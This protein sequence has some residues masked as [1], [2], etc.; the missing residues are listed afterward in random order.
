VSVASLL[1]AGVGAAPA[2]GHRD[3]VAGSQRAWL[4]AAEN[5]EMNVDFDVPSLRGL[6]VPL[7]E[8]INIMKAASMGRG[9]IQAL[10]DKIMLHRILNN[11]G[12]SQMPANLIIEGPLVNQ[13]EVEQ[14]LH[15]HLSDPGFA[16]AVVKPSHLSNSSG[17]L[18]VRAPLK[19]DKVYPI[20]QMI[21][22]HIRQFMRE[23]AAP[24]ESAALRSLKPGFMVQ[25]K[26]ANCGF[27]KPL[28]IRVV[29]L[30]GKARVAVWW[31]GGTPEEGSERNSWLVRRPAHRDTLDLGADDWELIHRHYAVDPNFDRAIE[32][33]RQHVQE[34]A[35]TAEMISTAVGA[36][37]MRTDFFVGDSKWGVRLNEVAYGSGIEYLTRDSSGRLVDDAPAIAEIIQEGMAR[38]RRRV[39]PQQLL[40]RLGVWGNNYEEL[41][42]TP[43]KAMPQMVTPQEQ[44]E[45]GN[46]ANQDFI[47]ERVVSLDY[48]VN[49][50]G[51][52]GE[53][54]TGWVLKETRIKHSQGRELHPDGRTYEGQY[55]YDKWN[56]QATISTLV[57]GDVYVGQYKDG[58]RS[59]EGKYTHANGEIYDGHWE[60][61]KR[62]G[63]GTNT[64]V[65][66]AKYV[67]ECKDNKR[68]G[69]GK[70]TYA[71]GDVYDGHWDNNNKSGKGKYTHAN[72]ETY[73]GHWENDKSNGQGTNTW[74]SGAKYVGEYKDGKRSGEG[75]Y[76]KPN[77][78]T[79]IGHWENDS[80][81]GYGKLTSASGEVQEGQWKN[82]KFVG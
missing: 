18:L 13:R 34:M 36:P 45:A 8:V 21:G 23:T 50:L 15:T 16:G 80:M 5:F 20:I 31:Y 41:I 65:S 37:F 81:N 11:L 22:D 46:K 25:P 24:T 26:Y 27:E 3:G 60:N 74:A 71:D 64:W 70:Y 62:N 32:L 12:V 55:Q 47:P 52:A 54:Y 78:D 28:E 2:A 9:T 29:T 82:D 4:E 48:V 63:R 40:S 35:R 77:G 30:W 17:V 7:V 66:G 14:F 39:P 51:S 67:G 38:C 56:G 53:L 57:H 58:K 69:E 73:D 44:E 43:Q 49:Q 42:I 19:P 1:P 61:D 6:R 33:F 76:T 79:Y 68:S 10:G 59:G 72:G 75:K